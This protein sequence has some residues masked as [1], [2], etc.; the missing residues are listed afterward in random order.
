MKVSPESL[1]INGSDCLNYKS[2]FV[3]GNDESYIYCFVEFLIKTFAEKG[4]IKK[5]LV[6]TTAVEPDLFGR[7]CKNIYFTDKYI[8]NTAVEEIENN[9]NVF[10]FYEK[11]TPKNKPLKSFFSSSGQRALVECY[12]LD[13]NKKRIVLNGFIQSHDLNFEKNIYW[14]L[15]DLLNNKFSLLIQ[16]LE[17]VLLL[18]DK[19]NANKLLDILSGDQSLVAGEFFF[20]LNLGGSEI[21]SFFNTSINSLSD[22]YSCF[23]YFKTYSLLLLNSKN[24]TDLQTKI[25]KYLFK[26]RENFLTLFRSLTEN[27]K[28]LLSALVYKTENLVRKNPDVFKPLFYRFVLNYK[29]I[30]S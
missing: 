21:T 18:K 9:Q 25:P 11:N 29:K 16:E 14:L 26:E 13:R 3:S 15:L 6:K 28:R 4:L 20:K 17:K 30:I 19:N 24:E 27:K 12:E 2:F 1:F 5:S 10:I 7:D 8:G 23:S 22:F